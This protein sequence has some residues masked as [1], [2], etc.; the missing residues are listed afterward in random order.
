MWLDVIIWLGYLYLTLVYFKAVKRW[1]GVLLPNIT[2]VIMAKQL[3]FCY[4]IFIQFMTLQNR[5]LFSYTISH[6]SPWILVPVFSFWTL[7]F[8]GGKSHLE[9]KN[10]CRGNVLYLPNHGSKP[11]HKSELVIKVHILI[12]WA[13][14]QSCDSQAIQCLNMNSL[15]APSTFQMRSFIVKT[16]TG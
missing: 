3:Y 11:Q 6:H 1:D 16:H 4:T 15:R 5:H 9:T 10:I 8:L 7:K 14:S 12:I 13:L 2:M